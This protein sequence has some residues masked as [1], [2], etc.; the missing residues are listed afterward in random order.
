MENKFYWL[1]L[2][3]DF[4]KRHDVLYIRSLPQGDE[5]VLFYLQLMLESVDHEGE[6]RFNEYI[7][8]NYSML[9]SITNSSQ[10]LVE[11]AMQQL[12]ALGLVE[13]EEDQTIRLPKVVKMIGSASDTDEARR[14]RRC[15]ERKKAERDKMSHEVV[16]DVTENV[17]DVTG[18]VTKDN[19]SKSKRKSKRKSKSIDIKRNIKEKEI[20][21]SDV[22]EKQVPDEKLKKA[23]VD[24]IEMRKLIKKPLT[25]QALKL[26]IGKVSELSGGNVEKAVQIID[27]SVLNNWQGLYPIKDDGASRSIHCGTS[28]NPYSIDCNQFTG[29]EAQ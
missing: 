5:I 2:K 25:P 29:G 6:L 4:F 3:K 22:L 27:Q 16:T 8:Y 28:S 26:A 12:R 7:P 13:I 9:A 23:F 10:D 20:S 24:F 14:Q 17:T 19:E 11:T 15:R 21:L 18:S 1:K